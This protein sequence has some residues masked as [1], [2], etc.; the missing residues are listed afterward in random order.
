VS[1]APIVRTVEVKASPETA[2]DLFA[3]HMQD[4]WPK[5][6]TIGKSPHVAI[7]IE[8]RGGGRW[9]ERDADG[10]ETDWGKVLA[11]EPPFRLLLGWQINSSWAYDPEML[12]EVELSFAATA[13]G[14]TSVTLEHRN[15]ERFGRDAARHAEKL[16]G[17][18]PIHLA[19]F[20]Q[21][22]NDRC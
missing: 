13:T 4:W 12:T 17:G 6:R 3:S 7:V 20:A 8:P 1:I 15:L 5:G 9:Y 2:F 22:T 18:W 10:Q 14:G 11:W 19:D 21:Y 16:G